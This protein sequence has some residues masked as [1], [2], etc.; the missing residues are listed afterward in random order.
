MAGRYAGIGRALPLHQADV[1]VALESAEPLEHAA[2]VGQRLG[3][4][5]LHGD[6]GL[7]WCGL[8]RSGFPQARAVAHGHPCVGRSPGLHAVADVGF[9]F[10]AGRFGRRRMFVLFCLFFTAG[11]LLVAAAITELSRDLVAFGIAVSSDVIAGA[12]VGTALGYVG[13]RIARQLAP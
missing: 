3:D 8:H 4:S 7:G 5:F 13:R 12:I 11:Q 10:L 2:V 9:G 1:P 6:P